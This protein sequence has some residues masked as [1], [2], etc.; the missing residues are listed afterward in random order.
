MNTA[1]YNDIVCYLRD[2]IK[3][4]QWQGIVYTVGGCCRDLV[5]EQ[6][7]KDIDLAVQYPDGGIAF[8]QWLHDKG[9]TVREPILFPKYST[10]RL[11]L[12]AFPDD[13]LEIVQTRREKYTDRTTRDPSIAFGT[14]EEDCYR[15]DLTINSLYYDISADKMLDIT[16]RALDDI[17]NHHI[18]T[19]SDPDATFDDDPVRIL[20]TIR[21]AAKYGWEISEHIMTTMQK[22]VGRLDIIS[23]ERMQGEFEK[24][25]TCPRPAMALDMLRQVGAIPYIIPELAKTFD[26]PQSEYHFGTVWQHTLAVVDKV[27]EQPLLRYAALL[28]DIGKIV[29][30][31]KDG[32]KIRFPRH[33]RRCQGIIGK[34]LGRLHHR[35][36][37]IDRVIFLC[38]N[39]EAAKSWGPNAENCSDAALRKL[40][41]LCRTTHRLENLL[42]LIDADNR[43]YAPEHCM[44]AQVKAIKKKSHRLRQT[45][46]AMFTYSL[47]IKQARIR[48]ILGNPADNQMEACLDM[49][50]NKAYQNPKLTR[51]QM[52][53]LVEKWKK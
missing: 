45:G 47:P 26:M 18:D 11:H 19:P 25:L 22:Y 50:M 20:R 46:T 24:I 51:E 35:S 49:L 28:H 38:V 36:S 7:I 34:M 10:S 3:D 17:R 37:F 23:P 27:P 6:Q 42:T 39:H 9:L 5:L 32:D 41:L 53:K 31:K 43:S 52:A 44:P 29:S 48:K 30:F 16:G 1:R 33:D 13:E 21:F 4:T 15:R 40:Q 2:L 8:A 14:I 12:K